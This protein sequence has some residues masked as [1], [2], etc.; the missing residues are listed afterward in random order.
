MLDG[1][2]PQGSPE[3]IQR[4]CQAWLQRYLAHRFE[5]LGANLSHDS[6]T[7]KS[8]PE[9]GSVDKGKLPRVAFAEHGEPDKKSTWGYPHHFVEGGELGDEGVY[10]SGTL[11]L[12]RGGLNAAWAAANG[13]RSGDKA[14]EHVIAHLQAHRRALGL[15]KED[16]KTSTPRTPVL[17]SRRE[18]IRKADQAARRQRSD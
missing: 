14:P 13:A 10:T 6:E 4:R 1:M 7:A 2:F 8:E 17:D 18:R 5:M 9:W 12:H 11:Y 16:G 15:D 3:E